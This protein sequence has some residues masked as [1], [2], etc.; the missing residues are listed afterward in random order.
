MTVFKGI[1]LAERS[2]GDKGKFIDVLTENNTVQEI[3]VRGAKKSSS[4]GLSTTQLFSYANFSA[5]PKGNRLY[6]NSAEPI[7]LFYRLRE[8]LT[9]LSLAS[10]FS[11]LV[12]RSIREFRNP[13]EHCEVLR[14]M[15][16]TLHYLEN[17]TRQEEFL[18]PL[19][20]LRLMTELGMMPNLLICNC[21]GAFEPK[22]LYFCV[23]AGCYVCRDCA[24]PEGRIPPILMGVATLKAMR[25]IVFADFDKLYNFRL[26]EENL[27]RLNLATEQF[28]NYHLGHRIP[29]LEFYHAIKN[30]MEE[31]HES[32]S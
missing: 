23:D 26:G 11:E 10:Y 25:H 5:E 13:E 15:L 20:E 32:T 3:Y 22:E 24:L 12:R 19:F 4:A 16:N 27:K 6:F 31:E 8:S 21:C 18:K 28:V 30:P 29:S 17:G 7:R 1:V 14:F 9:R 2:A